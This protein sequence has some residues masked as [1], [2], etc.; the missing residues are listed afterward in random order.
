MRNHIQPGDNITVP[1]APYALASG[2]GCLVGSL[3]GIA[4]GPADNAAEVVL[5]TRGVFRLN[6]L[7]TDYFSIGEPAFWDDTNKRVTTTATD[8]TRIGVAVAAS[9]AGVATVDVRLNGS[10]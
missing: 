8:N 2:A 6:K 4:S 1:A 10:F 9:P 3:F 7:T 5:A